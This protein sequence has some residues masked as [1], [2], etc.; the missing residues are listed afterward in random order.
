MMAAA[1]LVVLLAMLSWVQST[2]MMSA[3]G[4]RLL[5][6]PDN[7][8]VRYRDLMF[9]EGEDLDQRWQA[10]CTDPAASSAVGW[11]QVARAAAHW[12]RDR[13]RRGLPAPDEEVEAHARRMGSQQYGLLILA[14]YYA[15]TGRPERAWPLLRRALAAE[16]PRFRA[17]QAAVRSDLEAGRARDWRDLYMRQ[18]DGIARYGELASWE[19][20]LKT[21]L[22]LAPDDEARRLVVA[23]GRGIHPDFPYWQRQWQRCRVRPRE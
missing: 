1:G 23:L 5:S 18:G 6:H 9:A 16:S 20:I 2:R 8:R 14:D 11:I 19:R 12:G 13:Y 22:D 15:H 10:L 7:I 21:A 3:Y 17:W 4:S